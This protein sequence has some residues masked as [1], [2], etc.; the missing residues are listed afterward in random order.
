[1]PSSFFDG[2]GKTLLG[3]FK[4][5]T[6]ALYKPNSGSPYSIEII[7]NAVFQEQ[8]SSGIPIGAPK[9]VAWV[10]NFVEPEYGDILTV[11]PGKSD[12]QNYVVR[13]WKLDG[14]ELQQLTLT[15]A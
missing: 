10:E 3:I 6:P 12:E 11:N 9:P 5:R 1:M 14:L 4:E 13:E 2:M 15:V 8:D 7:F